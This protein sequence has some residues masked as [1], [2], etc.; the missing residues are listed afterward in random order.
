MPEE[1]AQRC[2]G[3]SAAAQPSETSEAPAGPSETPVSTVKSSGSDA[4]GAT[5]A[6]VAAEDAVAPPETDAT[7]TAAGPPPPVWPEPADDP[8]AGTGE[9]SAGAARGTIAGTLR[10]LPR[11]VRLVAAVLAVL[12]MSGAGVATAVWFVKSDE[13]P[14]PT[15]A[16]AGDCLDG[17]GI[18]PGSRQTRT[19]SLKTVSCVGT[20][21]RYKVVGRIDQQPESAARADSALCDGFPGTEYIYWEGTAGESGTVLCLAS[22]QP[23]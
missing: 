17:E 10:D 1:V 4:D 20:S 5:E 13:K 9:A 16:V 2:D 12:V 18:D 3:E 19:V 22:N 8:A 23:E 11:P 7:G 21:A 15:T 14:P 6:L